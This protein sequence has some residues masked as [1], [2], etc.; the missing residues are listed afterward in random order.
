MRGAAKS[1][2]KGL[3]AGMV[4]RTAAD[5]GRSRLRGYWSGVGRGEDWSARE[6]V[7]NNFEVQRTWIRSRFTASYQC[8]FREIINLLKL[9]LPHVL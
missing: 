3:V 4:R 9:K 5:F 8:D 1:Y 7:T 2:C 6:K